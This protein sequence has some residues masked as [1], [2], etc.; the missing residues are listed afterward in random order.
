MVRAIRAESIE[1]L[2]IFRARTWG[3]ETPTPSMVMRDAKDTLKG[4]A[5]ALD[6]KEHNGGT[7][8]RRGATAE[9]NQQRSQ[10]S[11]EIAGGKGETGRGES[12]PG[13]GRGQHDSPADGHSALVVEAPCKDIEGHL[14]VEGRRPAPDRGHGGEHQG[15]PGP[16][17]GDRVAPS[18][19]RVPTAPGSSV[20][21][22]STTAY[23]GY[24]RSRPGRSSD[25]VG[26]RDHEV[27]AEGCPCPDRAVARWNR[28]L[29][30]LGSRFGFGY[31]IAALMA[32]AFLVAFCVG[33]LR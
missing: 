9:R 30:W 4:A 13:P 2:A 16:V 8:R 15:D 29:D 21:G 24:Q 3:K 6:D 10:A 22:N 25:M 19:M 23:P 27:G 20:H 14:G 17:R 31:G 32:V 7:I 1:E 28:R 26:I 12:P 11:T 5:Q 18:A 33:T